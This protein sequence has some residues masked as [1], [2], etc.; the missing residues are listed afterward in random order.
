MPALSLPKIYSMPD[1]HVI[2][3]NTQD[4]V[5]EGQIDNYL[6]KMDA[7]PEVGGTHQGPSPKKVLLSTLAACTGID[8]VA[9]LH[10]MRVTFSDFE[11][12]TDADLTSE[13]PK[14]FTHIDLIYRIRVPH[15]DREKVEKAVHL[16]EEKYCG[17]SAML[18][19]NSPIHVRIEFLEPKA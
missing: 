4:F 1:F 18:K 6:F 14:V 10:K 7:N 2:T 17:I 9:M 8:V 19:K 12:V 11:I 15:E 5:F 16:S 13:H 3:R